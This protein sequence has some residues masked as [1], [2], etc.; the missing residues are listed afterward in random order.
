MQATSY[1]HRNTLSVAQRRSA[2]SR[3]PHRLALPGDRNHWQV[4][5]PE[6]RLDA[7]KLD[8][9]HAIIE[10]T[11][12]PS[13]RDCLLIKVISGAVEAFLAKPDQPVEAALR[14][15]TLLRCLGSR[16]AVVGR[17]FENLAN[18]F[19]VAR[20]AIQANLP[21][22]LVASPP[23]PTV[24]QSLGEH[25]LVFL[26]Q[27]LVYA[28]DGFDQMQAL[29]G[30]PAEFAGDTLRWALFVGKTDLGQA[31]LKKLAALAGL[32]LSSKVVPVVSLGAA[33]PPE[34]VDSPHVLVDAV[35]HEAIV[36]AAIGDAELVRLAADKCVLVVGPQARLQDAPR[37]LG[38]ARQAAVMLDSGMLIR[39]QKVLHC[40]EILGEL[41]S[42]ADPYLA[43]LLASKHLTLLEALA[44]QRRLDLAEVL[45]AW[46]ESGG[47][48]NQLAR[49]MALPTQTVH[50][51]IQ[52]LRKQ[53]GVALDDPRQR[54]E[55]I[56]A[57]RVV[58]PRWRLEA[59]E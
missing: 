17:D 4:E 57:L 55:L 46:L 51:R 35:S 58:M 48:V 19:K 45:L 54:V 56:F 20:N 22:L 30:M 42:Y 14:V 49:T 40:E 2:P 32:D 1:D 10:N 43:R 34:F 53:M 59:D 5:L 24:A 27:L 47:S 26:D 25:L 13:R 29:E 33:F 37:S 12:G 3:A 8:I 36:S 7:L 16:E 50:S 28:S 41:A 39:P 21:R 52:V 9:H 11:G 38:L 23:S 31:E 44:S 15:S 6:G 18:S